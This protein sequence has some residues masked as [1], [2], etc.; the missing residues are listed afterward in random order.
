ML[1]VIW[2][3]AGKILRA[4]LSVGWIGFAILLGWSLIL[5]V[6]LAL[7]WHV[8]CPGA[9]LRTVIWSR[10]V[11]E[12]G[13][14]CLPFS[15]VGGLVFGAR[16]LA[17]GGVA[18]PRAIASS[19]A[20]VSA[21]F[22]GEIPFIVFGVAMLIARGPRSSPILPLVIGLGLIAAGLAALFW[23]EKHAATLLHRIGRRIAGRSM[24]QAESGANAVQQ[25]FERLFGEPRRIGAAAAI[26]FA[27]WIGGG[28]TVWISYCLL[29]SRIGLGSAIAIE[30]LLSATL[31]VAFLVP[32]GIGVQEASYVAIGRLFGMPAHISLGISLLRRARDIAI[33]VPALLSWQRSEARELRRT[34][35]S[36]RHG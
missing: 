34:S 5:F 1:L 27:G 26:H 31:A 23:A 10:L 12:G 21:E 11:R 29:G 25:E 9:K 36:D 13:S 30:G 20:D 24:Q 19:I 3:G 33:G 8:V 18:W 32:G 22:I 4:V 17:L 2:L 15:G 7:A 16:A 6:V 14:N 35:K 28:M